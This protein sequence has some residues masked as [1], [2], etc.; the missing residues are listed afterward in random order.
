MQLRTLGDAFRGGEG[1]SVAGRRFSVQIRSIYAVLQ[2][3]AVPSGEQRRL[4]IPASDPPARTLLAV[5]VPESL[6]AVAS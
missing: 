4:R 1:S 2:K 5:P 3:A 6:T